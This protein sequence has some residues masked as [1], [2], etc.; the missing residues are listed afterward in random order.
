MLKIKPAYEDLEQRVKYL[1]SEIKFRDQ[2]S[3]RIR[4][5]SMAIEQSSEGVAVTNLDG[6]LRYINKAFAEMH[7]YSPNEIVGKNLSIFHTSD[8]M[9]SVDSAN[10][11]LKETGYFTG[12][13]WHVRR[14]GKVFPTIMNNSL[15]FDDNGVL[16][17]MTGTLRDISDL[18]QKELKLIESEE[19]YRNLIHNSIDGIVIVDGI[20]I[21]FVNQTTLKMF[22]FQSEEEM[23]GH[24]IVDFIS[25]EYRK[26]VTEIEKLRYIVQ[27]LFNRF[28]FRAVRKDGTEF[29]A[30]LSVRKIIYNGI[31][32]IRGVI[33]NISKQKQIE[34][35]IRKSHTNLLSL[36]ENTSD[37]ILISDEQ[38]FPILFNT[39]YAKIMKEAF[40]IEMKAGLKPH[41]LLEDKESREYWDILHDRVL[42]GEK[43]QS[44][45][46]HEF[47]KGDIRHFEISFHPIIN[48][49]VV[50]GFSEITRD[51][52]NRIKN[53]SALVKS[54]EKFSKLFKASPI[55]NALTSFRDGRF[56]D[57]NQAFEKIS[58]YSKAE[59]LGKTA[60]ELKFYPEISE[61]QKAMLILKNNGNL[62]NH[63][64]QFRR[65]TGEIRDVYW[66]AELIEIDNELCIVNAIV[67]MT[68]ILQIEKQS[69][70]TLIEKDLLL[71][72]V[73]HRV[74]NNMQIISSL[75]N[76]QSKKYN[77]DSIENVIED[78]TNR[79]QAM[80]LVHEL[81][82]SQD[83]LSKIDINNYLNKLFNYLKQQYVS[84]AKVIQNIISNN[85]IYLT[86]EKSIPFGLAMN[87]LISNSFKHAFKSQNIC[88][89]SIKSNI[90]DDNKIIIF[91]SDN[92]IGFPENTYWKNGNTLGLKMAVGLIESQLNGSISKIES[93][94]GT[95]FKIEFQSS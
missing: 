86:I 2:L 27:D 82:Y 29:F 37:Y 83:D 55:W 24:S 48:D 21:K 63:E 69:K 19:K 88:K 81:L 47:K 75:I 3:E 58:G 90:N 72:E 15:V 46:K 50:Q 9:Q 35:E 4:L 18:K 64:I 30:E 67:D 25:P 44:Y 16:I 91:M 42:S 93:K 32:V 94:V 8:Q 73:H 1:E 49:G 31:A 34:D 13:V 65:K 22:G 79:I 10:K 33:R 39:A 85:K 80:S 92:G 84:D 38:G 51:I 41:T 76:L 12:E 57:V 43:F 68:D 28:D 20:E 66:N 26:I 36:F 17:G 77:N 95:K 74:K 78:I 53:D 7:G 54:E 14:D 60:I 70:K 40:G 89:I 59:V 61:R 45:Y 71:K 87:E 5:L 52:T 6:N 62:I 23:I 11:Q 56:I